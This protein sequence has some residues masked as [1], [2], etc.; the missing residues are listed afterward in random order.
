L[1][2]CLSSVRAQSLEELEIILVDDGS[3]DL[4]LSIMQQH[5]KQDE[6]IVIIQSDNMH[7]SRARNIGYNQS[8]APYI[9]YVDDDDWLEPQM[10]ERL[11]QEAEE[12]NADLTVCNYFVEV[13]DEVSH[14]GMQV[15][16]S[17][18]VLPDEPWCA[19]S[20][21]Y[22]FEECM[23]PTVWNKLY[24]KTMLEEAKQKFADS[25]RIG[26]EDV[27]YNLC[28]LIHT[29]R[30]KVIP[31][32]L[33]HYRYRNDSITHSKRPEYITQH[34]CLLEEL[35]KYIRKVGKECE[36]ADV[37][38]RYAVSYILN[39]VIH[40]ISTNEPNCDIVQQLQVAMKQPHIKPMLSSVLKPSWL[41]G[42]SIYVW[43][44]HR[45]I[46]RIRTKCLSY[47]LLTGRCELFVIL[48]AVA[49]R[50]QKNQNEA[51]IEV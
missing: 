7:V 16:E 24:R 6:R 26:S 13:Q 31:D 50:L 14:L 22:F 19:E 38:G 32:A 36:L 45:W 10:V 28:Y 30:L 11:F 49:M 8:S 34:V 20:F 46:F 51:V 15:D 18:Y 3:T 41:R 4:S 47:M 2:Q 42:E 21:C 1:E 33:Y 27:L 23:G 17:F 40:G 44:G 5:A 12:N 9:L 43:K 48:I 37:M 25:K 35:W 29:K 39:A